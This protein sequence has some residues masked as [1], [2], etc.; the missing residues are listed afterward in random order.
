MVSKK[1]YEEVKQALK[2]E[3]ENRKFWEKSWIRETEESTR[4]KELLATAIYSMNKDSAEMF[5]EDL[6]WLKEKADKLD[7]YK[8][9]LGDSDI[10]VEW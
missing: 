5:A 4:Y 7:G 8:E 2:E 6:S 9:L 3:V 1:K 10:E